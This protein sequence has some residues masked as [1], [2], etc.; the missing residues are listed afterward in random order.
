M[1]SHFSS[2]RC[3]SKKEWKWWSGDFNTYED[4]IC[5]VNFWISL[6]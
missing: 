4:C 6:L 5:L 2:C 1:K 3:K